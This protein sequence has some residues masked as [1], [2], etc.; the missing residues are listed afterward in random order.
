M[1]ANL[2]PNSSWFTPSLLLGSTVYLYLNLFAFP[3]T[4]FLLGGDQV[5]FWMHAQRMLHGERI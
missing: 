3:A 5:Y 4:P 2:Q 1:R